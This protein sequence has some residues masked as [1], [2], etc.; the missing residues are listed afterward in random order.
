M[1]KGDKICGFDLMADESVLFYHRGMPDITPTQQK[2]SRIWELV[3]MAL[4]GSYFIYS[5]FSGGADSFLSLPVP[6]LIAIL[7]LI[8]AIRWLGPFVFNRLVRRK[9]KRWGQI[10]TTN[11]R[12]LLRNLITGQKR[13]IA[14]GDILSAELDYAKGSRVVSLKTAAAPNTP[15]ILE[16]ADAMD[17][18]AALNSD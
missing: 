5:I 12:L 14:R 9:S 10:A 7:A 17:A 13:D 11:K 16:V 6:F 1:D 15:I 18:Y 8:L 3:F 2:Q 4:V